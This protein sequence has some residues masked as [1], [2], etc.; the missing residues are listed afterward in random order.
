MNHYD[1]ERELLHWWNRRLSPPEPLQRDSN[2]LDL[3]LLD[4]L[5]IMDL[6]VM[7]EK[8]YA[9]VIENAA[10]SPRNFRTVA[11]MA[12]LCAERMAARQDRA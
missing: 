8:R 3:G 6:L 9:V 4:S 12:A 11:A 1:F 2:L 5:G 10:V 7:V